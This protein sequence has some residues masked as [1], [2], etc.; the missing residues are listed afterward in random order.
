MT[1]EKIV[2]VKTIVT[3]KGY[4]HENVK[5][6][7]FAEKEEEMKKLWIG[8]TQDF[9]I[10]YSRRRDYFEVTGILTRAGKMLRYSVKE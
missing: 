6:S 9:N 2:Q 10:A 8:L 7:G 3:S 5:V 1:I 4:K